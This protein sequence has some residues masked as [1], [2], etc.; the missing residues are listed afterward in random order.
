MD[1]ETVYPESYYTVLDSI[2]STSSTR[3]VV[4][5]IRQNANLF[6]RLSPAETGL[7]AILIAAFKPEHGSAVL[8]EILTLAGLVHYPIDHIFTYKA[9]NLINSKDYWTTNSVSDATSSNNDL[10][11]RNTMP[12]NI[13]HHTEILHDTLLHIASRSSNLKAVKFLLKQGASIDSVNCCGRTALMYSVMKTDIKIMKFF[14]KKGAN[15]N[16]Q[17]KFG[18]TA[19]MLSLLQED[20]KQSVILFEMLLMA[21]ANAKV[22]DQYGKTVVHYAFSYQFKLPNILLAM[23]KHSAFD[24]TYMPSGMVQYCGMPLAI[25]PQ[26]LT[27]PKSVR[28]LLPPAFELC[29]SCSFSAYYPQMFDSNSLYSLR[30]YMKTDISY[31]YP[32]CRPLYGNRTEISSIGAFISARAKPEWPTERLYQRLLTTERI[33]GLDSSQSLDC[34]KDVIA[35]KI[36]PEE[37]VSK[38][39]TFRHYD[40]TP[41][42]G[43]YETFEHLITSDSKSF[44]I[45]MQNMSFSD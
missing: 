19:L 24:L 2:L 39:L 41:G 7:Y 34:L 12:C 27:I 25:V 11:S 3:K 40:T 4:A 42:M 16:H 29:H 23:I 8:Q 17:D 1:L 36:Y 43:I 21:G 44:E 15:V 13:S 45:H 5:T 32:P 20:N 37:P 6:S 38:Y 33:L 28:S 18:H 30:Q 22:L 31:D 10:F 14:L 26:S 9:V 35:C